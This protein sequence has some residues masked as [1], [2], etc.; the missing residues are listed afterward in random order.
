M[1]LV[2]RRYPQLVHGRELDRLII[3]SY[4]RR[5][6]VCSGDIGHARVQGTIFSEWSFNGEFLCRL[7]RLAFS[8]VA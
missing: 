1:R 8:V 5:D 6:L 2:Q 4:K 3:F 7:K